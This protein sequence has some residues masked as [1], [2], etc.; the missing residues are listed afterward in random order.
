MPTPRRKYNPA[1]RARYQT[2]NEISAGASE[3][4]ERYE[5]AGVS[6]T[7]SR[8]T[9]DAAFARLAAIERIGRFIDID[10]RLRR[11][12]RVRMTEREREVLHISQKMID[13]NV[14]AAERRAYLCTETNTTARNVYKIL[15]RATMVIAY[16]EM[17]G[18]DYCW[19]PSGYKSWQPP[20]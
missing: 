20:D 8:P 1:L 10:Y 7:V 17:M 12:G 16:L 4:L 19:C 3:D 11:W 6:S 5:Y 13:Y 14:P 9:E 2:Y 15:R 18:E